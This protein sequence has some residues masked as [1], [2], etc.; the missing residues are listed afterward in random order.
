G[1]GSTPLPESRKAAGPTTAGK[2][3]TGRRIPGLRFF[4]AHEGRDSSIVSYDFDRCR[5]PKRAYMI[6]HSPPVCDILSIMKRGE[7]SACMPGKRYKR[8]STTWKRISPRI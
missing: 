3:K 1:S 5:S 2:R 6:K 7:K 8:P 4:Y